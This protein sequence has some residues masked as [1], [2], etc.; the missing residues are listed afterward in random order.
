MSFEPTGIVGRT[1]GPVSKCFVPLEPNFPDHG[2]G[3]ACTTKEQAI[4]VSI[5]DEMKL[6]YGTRELRR[7]INLVK[8]QVSANLLYMIWHHQSI[9]TFGSSS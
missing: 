8:K 3:L 5:R 6:C 9:G 4:S 1:Q 7:L 2:K